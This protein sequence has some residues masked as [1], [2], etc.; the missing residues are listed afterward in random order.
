MGC[1]TMPSYHAGKKWINSDYCGLGQAFGNGQNRT[2][3]Q[4]SP[5]GEGG[6]I[7]EKRPCSFR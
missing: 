5:G 4:F 3:L 2:P 6:T 1:E 7:P